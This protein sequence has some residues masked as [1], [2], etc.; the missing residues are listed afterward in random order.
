MGT[1]LWTAKDL[2]SMLNF[3]ACKKCLLMSMFLNVI[4]SAGGNNSNNIYIIINYLP[5]VRSEL[6]MIY[7]DCNIVQLII[8][9]LLLGA[10]LWRPAM[11][12]VYA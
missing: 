6:S 11:M 3:S 2:V 7:Y 12:C 1:R 4:E 9:V 8:T 10:A 5:V